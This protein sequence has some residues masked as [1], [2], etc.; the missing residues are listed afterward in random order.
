MD[1]HERALLRARIE[2]CDAVV[3]E[4]GDSPDPVAQRRLTT[5]L[6][7]KANM[8]GK[9]GDHA[10]RVTVWP[11]LRAAYIR[12]SDDEPDPLAIDRTLLGEAADLRRLHRPDE[13]LAVL[14]EVRARHAAAPGT[15][16]AGPN[17]Y[18]TALLQ[19]SDILASLARY[20][21]LADVDGELIECCCAR[22]RPLAR[23]VIAHALYHRAWALTALHRTD[24]ALADAAELARRLDAEQDPE[25][26]AAIAESA[27]RLAFSLLRIG[28]ATLRSVIKAAA[29]TA[30]GVIAE[31]GC[32]ALAI[33][34]IDAE[35]L[36]VP[37]LLSTLPGAAAVT[38]QRRR[39]RQAQVLSDAVIRRCAPAD[40]P[41]TSVTV[42]EARVLGAAA[43][44]GLG[45]VTTGTRA[46]TAL[47]SSGDVAVAEVF[48]RMAAARSDSG[49]ISELGSV[50]QLTTRA[51]TLGHGNPQITRIAF[52]ESMR[53]GSPG[54]PHSRLAGLISRFVAP[55]VPSS[56][57]ASDPGVL[58]HP[59]PAID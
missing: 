48:R 42:A 7:R 39:T 14:A 15:D 46:F 1:A 3:S 17:P 23:V 45:H 21:E 6:T 33:V 24:L 16:R 41:E 4:D 12:Q 28:D 54:A 55:G 38:E 11:Q 40:D 30:A 13:A 47:V 51:Q 53:P 25:I 2:E 31:G 34:H 44:T 5:A 8:L 59:P 27:V 9:L 36:P 10:E 50:A 20:P 26:A 32:H 35:A 49:L 57:G 18:V 58:L 37:R 29:I 56:S 22:P 52:E 43:T 19:S